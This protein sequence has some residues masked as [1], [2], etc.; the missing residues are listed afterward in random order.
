MVNGLTRPHTVVQA[1]GEG[2]SLANPNTKELTNLCPLKILRPCY[3]LLSRAKELWLFPYC[4]CSPPRSVPRLPLGSF[5]CSGPILLR[6]MLV[7][8]LGPFIGGGLL[9]FCLVIGRSKPVLCEGSDDESDN[10]SDIK[11]LAPFWRRHSDLEDDQLGGRRTSSSTPMELELFAASSTAA[12]ADVGGSSALRGNPPETAATTG[13][14]TPRP[15]LHRGGGPTTDV[16]RRS[17]V[18]F[19]QGRFGTR[20][21]K[22]CP[23][24]YGSDYLP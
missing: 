4:S 23:S 9:V 1:C 16:R 22:T 19:F 12:G 15:S 17:R 14:T 20:Y 3:C 21:V 13:R 2:Q 24:A 7:Q 5:Y 10:A 18:V 11:G 8:A 6:F